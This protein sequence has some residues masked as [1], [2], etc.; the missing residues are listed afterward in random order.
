ML[1]AT[2]EKSIRHM[3]DWFLCWELE[4]VVVGVGWGLVFMFMYVKIIFRLAS[5]ILF[6][7]VCQ[8]F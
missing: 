8:S 5:S 2:M 4:G 1:N 3:L 6:L 7:F